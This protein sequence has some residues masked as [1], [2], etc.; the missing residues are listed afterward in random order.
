MRAILE[1]KGVRVRLNAR[2]IEL[3]K[4]R[5]GAV[6]VQADCTEG[7]P[8]VSGSHLLLAIGRTPNTDDLGLEKSGVARDD[9]IYILVD[10]QLRTNV[11]GIWALGYRPPAPAVCSPWEVNPT[12]QPMAVV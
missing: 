7:A 10:N 12:S 9:H 3:R 5:D 6:G 4:L 11:P 2:C 8:R 1:R